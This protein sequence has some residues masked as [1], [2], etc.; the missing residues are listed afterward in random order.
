MKKLMIFFI[1]LNTL[2]INTFAKEYLVV[3]IGREVTIYNINGLTNSNYWGENVVIE[4][5]ES[6]LPDDI[7][8]QNS[9]APK[10]EWEIFMENKNGVYYSVLERS[11]KDYLELKNK[12][13]KLLIKNSININYLLAP[14][15][16]FILII[17][18]LLFKIRFKNKK[19]KELELNQRI[20]QLT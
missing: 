4:K 11:Q 12:Y 5:T 7:Y 20:S 13:Q 3:K 15:V 19:L 17:I 10:E 2:A 1:F 9:G 8:L 18:F 6:F 14:L 16:F